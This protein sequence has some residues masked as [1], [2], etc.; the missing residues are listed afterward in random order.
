[1]LEFDWT[2]ATPSQANKV[3][4]LA[5]SARK[6]AKTRSHQSESSRLPLVIRD[7]VDGQLGPILRVSTQVVEVRQ[8]PTWISGPAPADLL[9][10]WR[11]AGQRRRRRRSNRVKVK[12]EIAA[13]KFAGS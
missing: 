9:P 2:H 13:A 10:A 4:T 5:T 3:P 7:V 6:V 1:M 11:G 8:Q 12:C